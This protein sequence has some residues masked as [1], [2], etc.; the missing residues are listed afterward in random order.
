MQ[1]PSN[2]EN[3]PVYH[4]AANHRFALRQKRSP[5]LGSRSTMACALI[6]AHHKSLKNDRSPSK[7][8]QVHAIFLRHPP[9]FPPLQRGVAATTDICYL[10]PINHD[11][12]PTPRRN[13]ADNV[14]RAETRANRLS[15]G[16][17]HLCRINAR[18]ERRDRIRCQ[19]P[20][21]SHVEAG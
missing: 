20:P 2:F 21:T 17:R 11:H 7:S 5:K 8:S 16:A 4:V 15:N 18:T 6:S 19:Y 14:A 13:D 1:W 3:Q 9:R 10:V 12:P